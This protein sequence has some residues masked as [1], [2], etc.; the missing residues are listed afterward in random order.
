MSGS[1]QRESILR[2]LEEKLA[3]SQLSSP[4]ALPPNSAAMGPGTRRRLHGPLTIPGK[5]TAITGMRRSGK[6]FFLHQ[7]RHQSLM[8]G[9]SPDRLP[10]INFEDERLADIQG[11]DLASLVETYYRRFPAYRGSKPVYWHFDEIQTVPGWERFVRRLM[12]SEKAEIR[13]TGS[14]AA[15]LSR[16]I[17]TALRGRAWEVPLYPFGFAEYLDHNG[18]PVP[19]NADFLSGPARSV[20][21]SA[22]RNWLLSGG[23]PEIQGHPLEVRRAMLSDY[24]DVAILRDVIERHNLTNVVSVRWMVRNLLGNAG[25]P[26]SIEKFHAALKS[27]GLS[28]A[29]D[30]LHQILAHLEDCFLVHTLRIDSDSERRRMVNPRKAYPIDSG[31]IPIYTRSNKANLGHA[32]ETMIL[33]E[34]LRRHA[35]VDYIKTASGYE[36]DFVARLPSGHTELIQTCI[37]LEDP[38]TAE[39]EYRALLEAAPEYPDA[40]LRV[41]TLNRSLAIPDQPRGIIVQPAYEWI[42]QKP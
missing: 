31:F 6:T 30:T 16:E 32:L 28:V 12:D 27:Q 10:F 37:S 25:S 34:L 5:V 17:A 11:E 22:F 20:L 7:L 26:F 29:K 1:R 18:I 23:F 24:V 36:V 4:P 14:S 35:R 8:D 41:L 13:I 39:R 33:I 19:E 21:E 38:P 3:D 42:L 15:L 2:V 40:T 9:V